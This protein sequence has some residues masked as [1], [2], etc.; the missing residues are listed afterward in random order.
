MK[1]LELKER[2]KEYM[3]EWRAGNKSSVSQSLKRWNEEHPAYYKN[4]QEST[5]E[6]TF[7]AKESHEASLARAS[8]DAVYREALEAF[9]GLMLG[10]SGLVYRG[11]SAKF[12]LGLSGKKL[13]IPSSELI[14]Y[15]EHVRDALGILGIEAMLG[16]PKICRG[17]KRDGR[18][19]EYCELWTRVSAFLTLEHIRWYHEL[20][21]DGTAHK[22]VPGDLVITPIS[23]ASWFTGD[24]SSSFGNGPSVPVYLY[25]EGF[26]IRSVTLLE[27]QLHNLGLNT[28]RARARARRGSGVVVTMLQDSVNDFMGL[29]DPYVIEPY[30]YKVK[31]RMV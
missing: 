7:A 12:H 30:R 26:N 24:G 6:L 2:R 22:E 4:Y 10:D 21:P 18:S 15:L 31:Y 14:V 29:V 11:K 23:L 16:Y 20:Y 5:P 27:T 13:E 8:T 17:V 3:R 19:Y 1:S 9:D 25:T 28:G